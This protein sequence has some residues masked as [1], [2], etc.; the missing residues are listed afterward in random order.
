[1]RPGSYSLAAAYS[2]TSDKYKSSDDSQPLSVLKKDTATSASAGGSGS[3]KT[4]S[5]RLT[6][7][8]DATTGIAGVV[9]SLYADGSY[10][11]DAT[12]DASGAAA[13][14]VP[15]GARGKK[16]VYEVRFAGND[17][18]GSCSAQAS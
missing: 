10:V 18:Y 13:F 9:L 5:A 14:D 4:V 12:T 1:M 3:K 17:Y 8:N 16:T 7:A 15:A 2:G 11:G 6:N